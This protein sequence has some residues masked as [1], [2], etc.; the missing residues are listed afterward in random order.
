M[1]T[2][3]NLK[4]GTRLVGG[5]LIITA[6]F[7][8]FII[9]NY[10]QLQR[11]GLMQDDGARRA[12]DAL[13]AMETT[14]DGVELYQVIAD[15][16]I[17]LDFEDAAKEW[18]TAK[19]MTDK[20]MDLMSKAVD[21]PQ[22][23]AWLIEANAGYDQIVN[24]YENEML[25][26]LKAANASTAE[27]QKMDGEMDGYIAAMQAPLVKISDSL[28]AES[29]KGDEDF[30]TAYTGVISAS[31]I[32]GVIVALAAFWIGILLSRGITSPLNNV[33]Q[34]ALNISDGDL[35]QKLEY[36][37]KD[38]IGQLTETFRKMIAYL[39]NMANVAGKVANND[40]TESVTPKSDK[41]EL[42]NSFAKM[43][44]G[45]RD[46]VT[47][48]AE[49]ANSVS[50]AAAQLTT[51]AEQSGEATSQIAT[52]I[53]QVALGTAQQTEG[54]TKTSASVEQMGRAIDGVA[55]GAQEQAKAISQAS[56][57]TS[58]INAAI[59]QVAANAQAVTRDSAQAATYSR[60]GAKTV[61]ET[62]NGMEAIR[63]KVGL[64]ATKVEEMGTRS[65]EIGAIVE[66][67]EDI[68][69]QTN[70]LALNAAIEAARAGEQGKGF[71]VV[72]DEVRKLAERSSL[73][74]K[75]IAALIKGIQKTVSE[76][77][78]AMQASAQE[79][80]L[81]VTRAHSAGEVLD[82]IL[83]AAESVYKQAEEAGNTAAKVGAAAAELV[84]AVDAV[85]A[86]IEE[87]TAA[88]EEMA[89]N[90]SELTQAIENI[91]SVSE[92]NSASVEEV[93]ASTEEVSAQVEEVSASATSLMEM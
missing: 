24:L 8:A 49:S 77:V 55:K 30:D 37:S 41:D 81:G 44:A 54:V 23:E 1:K 40:L 57:I 29:I 71:A 27:T 86:V 50:I 87:N 67:I 14:T 80:E 60:D 65:E 56:Q 7:A 72:A 78:T 22:E 75:E 17:N 20:D 42:G 79:V 28:S 85:S 46:A 47:M 68:A 69:S 31:I 21:T 59:E 6:L 84:E 12:N 16:Q 11:L 48:I 62:I 74:T 93:S 66:T 32:I 39:L 89:A 83:G 43:I 36:Q 53:Q 76:A 2:I 52:T 45:L 18:D 5:F 4:I 3:N 58:R 64:S 61:K 19:A 35:S 51:A 26:A 88:T 73:A 38:E 25:P 92:E 91:A 63:S 33:L 13:L 10:T 70:L 34:A 82:N 90:S 15:T 9:Y